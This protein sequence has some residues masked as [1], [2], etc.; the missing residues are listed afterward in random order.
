MHNP[1]KTESLIIPPSY[2]LASGYTREFQQEIVKFA[3]DTTKRIALLSAPTGAGK[4]HG[5]RLMGSDNKMVL[6]VFPNNLLSNETLL[7]FKE[8]KERDI[9]LL[10]ASTINQVLREKREAGFTD[11]TQRMAIGFL[12]E[13]RKYIITNP[14]ILYNLLDNHYVHSA[15]EDS[16]SEL[17]KFNISTLIFDEFHVYS[18][19]QASVILA[20]SKLLGE[21]IKIIYASATLAPDLRLVLERLFDPREICEITARRRS[22]NS[23]DSVLLQGPIEFNFFRT[24]TVSFIRDHDH[25]FK[26]GNW[27]LIL[28]SIR[29]I[30]NAYSELIL[31]VP[32]SQI[33]IISAYHDPSYETYVTI[34]KSIGEKRIV[35][36]SNIVEQGINPPR[37]YD[38]FLIEPGFSPESIIQ[39][40]GR[41]GRGTKTLSRVYLSVQGTSAII[42]KRVGTIDEFFEF[43]SNFRFRR[44]R[45]PWSRSI[46]T[47]LWFIISKLT[48]NAQK[49]ILDNLRQDSANSS[50]LSGIFEAKK[51]DSNLC[52]DEWIHSNSKYLRELEEIS[53]WWKLYKASIYRFIPSQSEMKILDT[54]ADFV[55]GADFI[56]E[57]SSLWIRKNREIKEFGEDF[58]E[59]GEFLE[60]PDFDFKVRV[61]GL[62]FSQQVPMRYGDIIFNARHEILSRFE[63]IRS[64]Y[65]NLTE[66]LENFLES[67]GNCIKSTAGLE[68]LT[69]ELI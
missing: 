44:D 15:R 19:D 5:F 32:K 59:V 55:E 54:A 26:T 11:F 28:D 42:P 12:L 65:F 29:N 9:A 25:L 50:L 47:Y 33:A 48:R 66:E 21:D 22:E 43:F 69:L 52:N 53:K 2:L 46:A 18:R 36:G 60:K 30:S 20:L 23:E 62:P 16:L 39:R 49:A 31:H 24:S 1:E 38:N 27:F 61:S 4:T 3:S 58:I 8:G 13:G 17:L 6:L 67:L 7:S 68:R 34:S 10:N 64:S 51:T 40:V 41:V 57:Y 45:I 35:I 37:E 56:T 63:R 14:T